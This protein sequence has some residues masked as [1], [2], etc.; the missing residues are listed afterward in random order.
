[1]L[2]DAQVRKAKPADKDYKLSDSLGL[3]LFV[4]RKGAKSW[5][6]KYRTGGK[7]KRLTFGLYPNVS[8]EQAREMRNDARKQMREGNDPQVLLQKRKLAG[9]VGSDRRFE[10]L[11]R[12]W[13]ELQKPRWAEH[14]AQQVQESLEDNV[15]PHIGQMPIEAIDIPTVLGVLKKV[16]ARGARETARR[17][18]Q[19][20]SAIFLYANAHGIAVP[21]AAPAEMTKVMAPLPKKTRQPAVRTVDEAQA[22]L[23]AAEGSG[24]SP[25]TKLA[26]RLLALTAVRPGA[27][28]GA[29]WDEFHNIDGEEPYWHI[30]AE[31]MKL[32]KDKKD[33][34]AFDHIVPLSRQAVEVLQAVARLTRNA[35]FVFPGQRHTHRPL[36]ENAIG[37]LYNRVGYQGRHVP[38]GW[39]STF[40]TVMN[41][42]AERTGRAS[43][44]AIIDL[45]L[46][47]VPENEVESAYNRAA[48]MP[49]RREIAQEWA[50]LLMEGMIP[51][52][53]LLYGPR[54]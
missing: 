10:T 30:K 25:I 23:A 31:R 38:H 51:A 19:R 9:E 3:Y 49:R 27:L 33:E 54:R 36:S 39:R 1:M 35:P 22:V 21:N 6:W 12:A 5:R 17:I 48:F 14:H 40:S 34:E 2:T 32:R 47:H 50:D 45:M 28:R 41:E 53:D 7:E 29:P 26:S 44:R 15:F 4:T 52:K 11:A 18:R 46:A 24:A 20:I 16:E 43:D 8:L 13:H 37:Y 42:R